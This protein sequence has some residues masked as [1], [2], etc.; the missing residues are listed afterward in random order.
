MK[1]ADNEVGGAEQHGVVAEG[2]RHRQ[3]NAEHRAHRG[4]HHE[5]NATF[6]DV[7]GARQ[8]R[9]GGPCPPERR[10]NQRPT[11][12]S[13]PRRVVRKQERDLGHREHED[14]VEEEL[15]RRDRVLVAALLLALGVGHAW[16]LAQ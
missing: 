13:A 1:E 10:E 5:A 8:P 9:V 2:A 7:H 6:V 3:G 12:S 4:E 16:T 11:K 15:E 14:Q